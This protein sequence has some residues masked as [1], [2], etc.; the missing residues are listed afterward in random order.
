MSEVWSRKEKQGPETGHDSRRPVAG[1]AR[2]GRLNQEAAVLSLKTNSVCAFV[3]NYLLCVRVEKRT[4]YF[5]ICVI[6]VPSLSDFV[7]DNLTTMNI[8]RNG[9]NR[10]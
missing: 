9:L 8:L 5:E 2:P 3:E 4:L 10:I 1:T 6:I 7:A